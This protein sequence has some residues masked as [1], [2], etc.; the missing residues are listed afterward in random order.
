MRFR[1]IC[2]SGLIAASL[3]GCSPSRWGHYEIPFDEARARLMKADIT[4]FRNARQCG[5]LIHFALNTPDPQSVGWV[6]TYKERT[7]AKFFVRL[8]AAESGVDA[9]FVIPSGPNGGEIY[10]GKQAYDYPVLLQPLRP[11]LQELVDSAMA[12]RHFEAERIPDEHPSVASDGT[13][14][15][16]R[17]RGV[18]SNTQNVCFESRQGLERGQPWSMSD[19]PGF[20]PM[21]P[22]WPKQ[23]SQ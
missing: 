9:D 15:S 4:G 1:L 17:D 18:I 12:Q 6:V 10:D 23:A 22:S 3:A 16:A 7:V 2:V 8:T 20:P 13:F 14:N 21:D 19:P 5:Y 11:A